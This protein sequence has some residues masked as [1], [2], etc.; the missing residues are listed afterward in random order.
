MKAFKTLFQRLDNTTKTSLK[1]Q[2]LQEFFDEAPD[3]VVIHGIHA[4]LGKRGDAP[5]STSQ[6]KD[7]LKQVVDIDDWMYRRCYEEVGDT[8]ETISLLLPVDRAEA[9]RTIV[10]WYRELRRL[11]RAKSYQKSVIL[12][13]WYRD[14][15]PDTVFLVNKLITG[16]F[17]VGVSEKTVVNA[18]ATSTGVGEDILLHRLIGD[19]K[20]TTAFYDSLRSEPSDE[21]LSRKPY[22]FCLCYPVDNPEDELDQADEYVFEWKYDGIRAQLLQREEPLLWSRGGE[23]LN[24]TFPEIIRAAQGLEDDVVLDGEI[25]AY[26]D[27]P[28]P[29][30]SLQR[31]LGRRDPSQSLRSEVPVVFIVYDVLERDDEDIRDQPLH[32]RRAHLEQLE[33]PDKVRRAEQ[34]WFSD[35]PSAADALDGSRSHDV[36]GFMVKHIKSVYHAGRKKQGWW[37]WKLDPFS[38]DAVL[39]YAK[40]GHGE[41][42]GMYTDYTF[43]VRNEDG[44]LLPIAKAYSGLTDDEIEDL[45]KWIRGNTIDQFGPVREV[46]KQQVFEIAFQGIYENENKKSGFATR[47]PRMV[48]WRKNKDAEEADTIKRCQELVDSYG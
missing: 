39:M 3:D 37:K 36:E 48:R 14:C 18:L 5:A 26:D 12:R 9:E 21:E 40:T 11:S 33:L 29:F 34:Q 42:N 19:W 6:M 47:F 32:Q 1:E 17:R 20:P 41:R 16:G 30:Q 24:E 23:P 7:A 44:E 45:D 46:K 35:W 43:G 15:D 13:G 38:L 28:L 25:L 31:R 2:A 4:L 22:P 10:D 8:A 27:D